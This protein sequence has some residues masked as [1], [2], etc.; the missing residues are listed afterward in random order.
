M[1]THKNNLI[2]Y[3]FGLI[4]LA[5]GLILNALNI[6]KD[7][8]LSFGSVGDYL[9][10]IGII[11]FIIM[12][13]RSFYPKKRIVDERMLSVAAKANR[14]VFLAVIFGAF[15]IMIIDGIRP[16]TMRYSFF[17]SAFVCAILLVYVVSY[18]I[19]LKY[20]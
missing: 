17:M 13:V 16:I 20:N 4:S 6:G 1:E 2:R 8:F 7:T 14:I 12:L 5:V 10:Y 15:V 3:A 9:I 18:K 11:A 19:L